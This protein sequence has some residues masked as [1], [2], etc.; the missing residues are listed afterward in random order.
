MAMEKRTVTG[1]LLA[2]LLSI[3]AVWAFFE[4]ETE[5]RCI[6]PVMGT[7]CECSFEMKEKDFNAAVNVVRAAFDKVIKI[8][9]IH[10]K[11]SELAHLNAAAHEK[12]FV[13]S[14]ELY[15]LLKKSREA[16]RISNG[17]FDI[18]VKPLMDLWGF[19]RKEKKI[20]SE[21]V[22]RQTRMLC[23]LD[24]VVF[25]D[26]KRTV[27]FPVKGMAFDLGGIAKGY[28]LDSAVKL[29]AERGITVKSG[30]LNLGG[31]L[32]IFGKDNICNVGIK[33]PSNPQ[34]IKSCIS[35]SAPGA[36]SSSGDYER[37]VVIQN[38]KFGHI[39]DPLTGMPAVRNHAATVFAPKGID[40]D[41][42]STVLFLGGEDIKNKLDCQSWIVR[43]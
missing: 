30:V 12:P 9:N 24:K 32:W 26:Q 16:Y 38:K 20:P 28:A 31:N 6:F 21:D 7:V 34:K 10:D 8:A 18:S 13:C 39:I 41:W 2:L 33:D 42:M 29:L 11:N 15:Y 4:R 40:S 23:G 5:N 3:A 25:D 36:V 35:I 22:L 19:Y 37:Y 14:E 43:K 17:R 1:I 27:F